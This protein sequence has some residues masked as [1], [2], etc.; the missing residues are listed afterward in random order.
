M[1][2]SSI[3]FSNNGNKLNKKLKDLFLNDNLYSYG[4]EDGLLKKNTNLNE[5]AESAFLNSEIII[6]IGAVGIAVRAIAPFIKNKGVDPAVIV[7]DDKGNYVIPILSGHL[8]GANITAMKISEFLS[9]KAVITTATDINAVWAADTWAKENECEIADISKIKFISSALLKGE[10]IGLVSDFE[11]KGKLPENV[12]LDEN[13]E[14]GVVIS[15]FNKQPFKNTLNI[16]PK[17]LNLGVGSKKNNDKNSLI[18]LFYDVVNEKNLFEQ[19]VK[20]IATINIKE[21][22]ICILKLCEKLNKKIKTFTSNELS[23]V[24]GNFTSSD[25]VKSIVGV[26][27]VCER[28]SVL[29]G[30]G[31]LIVRKTN[32]N[33]VTLAICQEDWRVCFENSNVRDRL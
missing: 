32:G 19:A 11:I 22:E 33:G 13:C 6:F 25:F 21:N 3:S 16:I 27:N 23:D 14:N 5:W 2:I 31:K 18:N 12:I 10:K 8:G 30:G 24:K 29:L 28:A 7:I 15:V 20:S 1:N 17:V 26:D 9:A 4:N